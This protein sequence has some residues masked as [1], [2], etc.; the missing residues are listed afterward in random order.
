MNGISP[1]NRILVDPVTRLQNK[2]QLHLPF[3]TLVVS[4]AP[5]FNYCY[6]V[7][8][9]YMQQNSCIILIPSFN[10]FL[11]FLLAKIY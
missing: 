5:E 10:F 1:S 2:T 4:L 7:N 9:V 11:L 3:P 8:E 6:I